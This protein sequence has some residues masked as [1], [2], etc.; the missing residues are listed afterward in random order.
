MSVST[1]A[2]ELTLDSLC[3]IFPWI[4]P[5][6]EDDTV[7]E[8][9]IVTTAR[10]G[11]GV[12][13]FFEQ[14]GRLFRV[15][16]AQADL[17]AV[18]RLV[19]AIARPLGKDPKNEPMLDARL[20]DGSRVAI[21]VPPASGAP[22]VTI[23]RF[24][25]VVLTAADLV[26]SGSL[27]QTVLDLL[28]AALAGGRNVLVAGGTG[29]GK[30]TL[31]NALIRMFPEDHRILVIEDTIELR[32]EQLN[33]VRLEARHFEGET[34]SIRHM[35]K[36]AL[37]HRPDH[38]V[39][40]E[41]RGAEAHDVLQALNT[42]HGASLTTIHA[43]SASDALYRMASCAMQVP[44]R[45]PWDVVCHG[46]ATA[47]E[48]VV[49]QHRRPDGTRGVSEI[50]R[51]NGFDRQTDDWKIEPVW[52]AA[53][54][55]SPERKAAVLPPI[56]VSRVG[57]EVVAVRAGVPAAERHVP[58]DAA[59]PATLASPLAPGLPS[60]SV[61][62]LFRRREVVS[63]ADY[64][65]DLTDGP[66]SYVVVRYPDGDAYLPGPSD[67]AGALRVAASVDPAAVPD[68]VVTPAAE[69]VPVADPPLVSSVDV[70]EPGVTLDPAF[71][72]PV[73]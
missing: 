66:E 27:P 25:K 61:I 51:V 28:G 32:V 1:V 54:S 21:C 30:T 37:R 52:S 6:V 62:E 20:S 43:N 53:A 71:V 59:D 8:I 40:G 56:A 72:D 68:V 13:V 31:L 10:R 42:G 73:L 57:D 17:R 14:K 29:S 60:A 50:I 39:V 70:P 7:T 9:M 4:A 63:L 46:V 35:V 47:F 22:A 33:T 65:P 48:L 24:S 69:T 55:G 38:I 18:E 67:P 34:L 44:D 45:L 11:L 5:L 16:A 36:H 64:E 3:A 49:H 41:I 23:R 58:V 26:R 2:A 15:R 12:M 19:I